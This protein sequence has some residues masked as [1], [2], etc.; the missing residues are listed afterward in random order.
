MQQEQSYMLELNDLSATNIGRE[1][2]NI[3]EVHLN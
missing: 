2:M 1:D 3:P